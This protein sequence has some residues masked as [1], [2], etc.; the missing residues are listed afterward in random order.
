MFLYLRP[1]L[2]VR[3]GSIAFAI[4]RLGVSLSNNAIKRDRFSATR[5]ALHSKCAPHGGR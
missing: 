3:F 2:M 1:A 5:F 4:V